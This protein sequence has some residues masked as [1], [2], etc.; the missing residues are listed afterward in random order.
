MEKLDLLAYLD[1]N[2]EP[3]ALETSLSLDVAYPTVAMALLRLL[4]QGLVA[5]YRDPDRCLYWYEL[6]EKGEARLDYLAGAEDGD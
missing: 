3:D 5:R 6:S 2:D 1:A 4:R